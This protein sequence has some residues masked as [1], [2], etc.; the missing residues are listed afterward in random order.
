MSPEGAVLCKELAS[1]IEEDGGIA[2]MIDY[3]HDGK[4]MDTFRVC[5]PVFTFGGKL[6]L[7]FFPFQLVIN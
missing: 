3:G 7:L 4:D 2:L 6:S 5:S 1:R